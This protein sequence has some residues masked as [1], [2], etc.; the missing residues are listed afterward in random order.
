[1]EGFLDEMVADKTGF[2][3]K[4]KKQVGREGGSEGDETRRWAVQSGGA[5][6]SC[7]CRLLVS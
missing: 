1:M 6:S 2:S 7:L 5:S 4:V 3:E